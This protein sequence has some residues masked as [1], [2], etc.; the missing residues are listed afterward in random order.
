LP[1]FA[2]RTSFTWHGWQMNESSVTGASQ[3]GQRQ[4]L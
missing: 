4:A 2:Q 3:Y 1:H